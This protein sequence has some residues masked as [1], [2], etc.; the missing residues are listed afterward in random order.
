MKS[1]AITKGNNDIHRKLSSELFGEGVNNDVT[2][3]TTTGNTP[4]RNYTT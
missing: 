4:S 1:V 3:T 2:L